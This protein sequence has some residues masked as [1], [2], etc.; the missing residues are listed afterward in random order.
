MFQ[1]VHPW[2]ALEQ[3]LKGDRQ[4]CVAQGT[5]QHNFLQTMNNYVSGYNC[6]QNALAP[7]CMSTV[8]SATTLDLYISTL[9]GRKSGSVTVSS[10]V[11]WADSV[12]LNFEAADLVTTSSSKSGTTSSIT[13]ISTRAV[14]DI[15]SHGLSTGAKAG[16][17]VGVAIGVIALL[18][19]GALLGALLLRQRQ[20]KVNA[21][22][23]TAAD[24]LPY[25]IDSKPRID[26][27]NPDPRRDEPG[28][29][30]ELDEIPASQGLDV[31]S[32]ADSNP[33]PAEL[34]QRSRVDVNPNPEDLDATIRS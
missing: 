20:R 16:I 22:Q 14:T 7:A 9:S 8:S 10:T 5:A 18:L 1:P 34:G 11:A 23:S 21:Q 24:Q 13:S 31:T 25:G 33:K 6:N 27:Q 15:Q 19:L 28:L 2:D 26:G 17:G 32:R 29:R 3:P 4:W 30:P 12:Q